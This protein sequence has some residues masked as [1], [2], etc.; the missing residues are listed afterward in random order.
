MVRSVCRN[1]YAFGV[2]DVGD[3]VNDLTFGCAVDVD[4][5]I[6]CGVFA[7][8]V[9]SGDVCAPNGNVYLGSLNDV[10]VAI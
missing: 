9:R 5:E 8:N 6:D 4:F 7:F 3:D 1:D 10:D 2:N